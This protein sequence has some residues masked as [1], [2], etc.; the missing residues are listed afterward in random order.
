MTSQKKISVSFVSLGCFKNIVDTEVLGGLLEKKNIE[1][2][3]PYENSNWLVINTCGFIRD[4]KEESIDEILAALEKKVKGEVSHVAIFGCLLQRYYQDLKDTFNA[5]DVIWGVNDLNELAEVIANVSAGKQVSEREMYP[6]KD[7][8]LFLYNHQ[9]KRIISTTPN[10]TFIKISEGCNMKCSFCAIPLIRGPY[11]SRE[12]DSIVKEAEKYKDM[13]FQELNLISQNSTYFGKDRSEKSELPQLLEALSKIN[14]NSV[15]VL[16]LMPEEVTDEIIDAFSYPSIIPYFDL[17]FQHVS[18]RILKLMNRSGGLEKNAQM[19]KKIRSKFKDAVIRTSFIVGFPGETEKDFMQLLEFARM[20]Q[21]ERI[22][23]FGFSEE[24]NTE[25]F[26]L[27]EKVPLEIIEER[28]ELLMNISDENI[29][30]YN[31]KLVDTV[32]DF[33]PLGPWDNYSTIGRIKS[34]APDTDGLTRVNTPFDENYTMYRI[35]VTGFEHEMVY[36]VKI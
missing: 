15:R 34:Q 9:Y 30:N 20:S 25:A 33:L 18:P 26:D 16:Y 4:A 35:N 19:I 3:S 1:I 31:Q 5:A 29:E 32:Q 2:V 23:V 14:F 11:R 7:R 17:P 28:K 22:G 27:K 12:I 10:V 36:G 13:G 24:E 6:N 21:I 8:S